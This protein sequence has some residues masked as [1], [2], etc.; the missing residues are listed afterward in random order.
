MKIT[1]KKKKPKGILSE[2]IYSFIYGKAGGLK[3]YMSCLDIYPKN[4]MNISYNLNVE[5]EYEPLAICV[6]AHTIHQR[7]MHL[8]TCMKYRM[9]MDAKQTVASNLC[10]LPLILLHTNSSKY[11]WTAINKSHGHEG[12]DSTSTCSLV[13]IFPSKS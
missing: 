9:P 11:K 5:T 1:K 12:Q 13:W 4:K 8:A 3:F 2:D 6:Y 7:S 10:D